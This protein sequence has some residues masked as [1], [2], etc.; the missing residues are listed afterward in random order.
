MADPWELILYQ[1]YAG[2]PGV[3]YDQSPGRGNHGVAVN[4]AD[5]DFLAD[6][7]T[8]GSGAVRFDAPGAAIRIPANKSWQ[9]LDAVRAEVTLF[10]EPE[11]VFQDN[12]SR[13]QVSRII[14][15]GSVQFEVR[16]GQLRAWFVSY[17][18]RYSEVNT[19]LHALTPGFQIPTGRWMTVGFLHDGLA[20]Q[21]LSLDGE[22]VARADRPIWPVAAAGEIT[23]GN[24]PSGGLPIRGLLDEVKVW[25]INPH[26]VDDEFTSRPVDESVKE[27]WAQWSRALGA[28]LNE[29]RECAV[30]LRDLLVRAIDSIVRDGL[31]HGDQTRARWEDASDTYRKLWSE[32]NLA[33][34][35]PMMADLISY[36]QLVG[37]DPSQNADVATLLNDDCLK[38]IL[39]RAPKMECDPQFTD[40]LGAL[41]KTV[42]RRNRGA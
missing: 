31:N 24:A 35:V 14:D 19:D 23:I 33:D 30:R 39:R 13:I 11:R 25:R 15:A 4:L 32:G 7:A 10:L 8:L 5:G 36:L 28:V 17:P 41:T 2:T 26:R 21:E 6:G 29:N 42:T 1:T 40:M 3:I 37:L 9:P 22:V 12:I 34:I 18:L 20:I 16:S 27:C 38:T